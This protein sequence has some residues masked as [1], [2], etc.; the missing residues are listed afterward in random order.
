MKSTQHDTTLRFAVV[1]L[2]AIATSL[3]PVKAHAD[4]KHFIG[5]YRPG[6]EGNEDSRLVFI[7]IVADGPFNVKNAQDS[8]RQAF[9]FVMDNVRKGNMRTHNMIPIQCHTSPGEYFLISGWINV[10][11][12]RSAW[13]AMVNATPT[14]SEWL[15]NDGLFGQSKTWVPHTWINAGYKIR[16]Q[17]RNTSDSTMQIVPDHD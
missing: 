7:T 9:G 13:V 8:F 16:I 11:D 3:F 10:D 2:L 14:T 12:G 5:N 15:R 1:V 17:T 4:L 6:F